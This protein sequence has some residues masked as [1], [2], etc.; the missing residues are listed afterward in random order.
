M[1]FRFSF[2]ARALKL[3]ATRTIFFFNFL[4]SR[5]NASFPNSISMS[6]AGRGSFRGRGRLGSTRAN[7]SRNNTLPNQNLNAEPSNVDQRFEDIKICDEIDAKLGFER[8]QEGPEKLGWLINMHS[9]S[10]L[11][12]VPLRPCSTT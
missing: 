8:Y 5:T 4:G 10:Y 6:T 7:K 1:D 9:V 12:V 2:L 11:I 3:F